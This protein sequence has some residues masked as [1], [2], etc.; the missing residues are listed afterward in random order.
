MNSNKRMKYASAPTYGMQKRG[1][2]KKA[3]SLPQ[4]SAPDF[5]QIPPQNNVGA[6][7]GNPAFPPAPFMQSSP[8]APFANF[9][10][11]Q[12]QAV[13]FG[14]GIPPVQA[15][16][17][18][19]SAPAP[20]AAPFSAPPM[21]QQPLGN[22]PL[23]PFAAQ[24]KNPNSFMPR[25]QGFVPP[26]P[27][28][29]NYPG[30]AAPAAFPPPQAAAPPPYFPMGQQAPQI[31]PVPPMPAAPFMQNPASMGFP[32]MNPPNQNGG[33][34]PFIPQPISPPPNVN[35]AYQADGSDKLWIGFL[36]V[37]LPLMFIA[38][39][40]LPVSFHILRYVFLGFCVIGLVAMWYRQ[41]FTTTTR[42]TVSILYTALCVVTLSFLFNGAD[43]TR[44]DTPG[45][46]PA[47]AQ[48][49]QQP[50][51]PDSIILPEEP[52]FSPAPLVA[53]G[54]SE[55][56]ERLSLFMD[57]WF[58]GNRV[59]EMVSLIQ[60]SWA[61]TRENAASDLFAL[62][63]NRT[64]LEYNIEEISGTDAD[65]SRTVSMTAL[66]DKNNGKDPI[67]YRFLILMVKEDSAWYVNPN[68]LATNDTTPT[69]TPVVDPNATP[70]T[71][72]M[73]LQP[74]MTETPVPP[75]TTL[76]YYNPSGGSFYHADAECSRVDR[77]FLPLQG[78][79]AYNDLAAYIKERK[80]NP[81][82]SCNAP[83][84]PLPTPAE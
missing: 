50:D 38:A 58:S 51:V 5:S 15:F 36:F 4:V 84:K 78:S 30:N 83:T 11:P 81:C 76:L 27:P 1:F 37:L 63:Q 12:Q 25:Q 28:M 68:S 9:V 74:R 48:T 29:P 73:T 10:P 41:M 56:E 75:G 77:K 39:L 13:P 2:S 42:A 72:P 14:G 40:F 46:V 23:I 82:L 16:P 32:P 20:S 52:E 22:T 6:S 47:A 66:I 44:P 57:L 71:P 19:H 70:T 45:G 54:K 43:I 60:P 65:N 17:Y 8:M 64:P 35:P 69:D 61:S 7:F 33:S 80:F 53:P 59:S 18:S 49:T 79:F 34:G 21:Q 55:A 3:A 67:R 31:Q 24:R 26:A 62:L